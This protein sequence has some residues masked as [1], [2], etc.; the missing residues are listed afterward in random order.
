[1]SNSKSTKQN[2]GKQLERED[3]WPAH[4]GTGEGGSQLL[5]GN[6]AGG[7]RVRPRISSGERKKPS[8]QI[9]IPGKITLPE[10]R[11]N[12]DVLRKTKVVDSSTADL[13]LQ[14]MLKEVL[15]GGGSDTGQTLGV[16]DD[17]WQQMDK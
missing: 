14:K 5:A 4:R 2:C 11:R 6:H 1:M 9:S 16:S 7:K 3:T 12:E 13:S 17:G 10:S 8:T 15:R